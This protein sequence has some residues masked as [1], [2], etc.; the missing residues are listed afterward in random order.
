MNFEK[1]L[2]EIVKVNDSIR[3]IFVT[4]ED[5]KLAHSR[6]STNTFLLNDKQVSLLGV[7][8]QV[9]RRLLNL[10][11]EIIGKNTFVHL[12]RERVHV[13]IYYIDKWIILVSCDRKTD[14]HVLTDIS[15]KIE[16]LI[17]DAK[18]HH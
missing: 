4:D 9:L 17:N 1:L 16:S 18:S 2:D 10:Y 8:M 13:L 15:I 14:K 3:F 5:G 7:D 11:D 6:V 12:I